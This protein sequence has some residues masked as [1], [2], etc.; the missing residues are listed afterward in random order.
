MVRGKRS[1]VQAGHVQP[2][3]RIAYGYRAGAVEGKGSLV[4]FEL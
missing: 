1:K 4:V 2:V 3:G